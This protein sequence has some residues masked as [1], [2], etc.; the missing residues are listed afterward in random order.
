MPEDEDPFDKTP[1]CP[2][3]ES[4]YIPECMGYCHN[5]DLKGLKVNAKEG[6]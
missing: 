3:C 5:E 4:G 1:T 2:H 6:G